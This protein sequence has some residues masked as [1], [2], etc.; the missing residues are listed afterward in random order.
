M[1]I[2]PELGFYSCA[3]HEEGDARDRVWG[4]PGFL[5]PRTPR[6]DSS[7]TVAPRGTTTLRGATWRS[8]YHTRAGQ[9]TREEAPTAHLDVPRPGLATLFAHICGNAGAIGDA[10]QMIG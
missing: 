4:S 3:A 10:E 7:G 2:I 8:L 6:E 1:N 9:S 5:C